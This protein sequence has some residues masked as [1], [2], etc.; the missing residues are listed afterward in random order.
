MKNWKETGAGSD[1]QESCKSLEWGAQFPTV[2]A[3]EAWVI[4]F[5]Y[6]EERGPQKSGELKDI[7]SGIYVT[8]M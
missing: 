7:H 5:P 4:L 2:Y 6:E 8:L 3:M 1:Q